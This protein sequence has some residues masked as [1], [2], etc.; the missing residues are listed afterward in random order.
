VFS[1]YGISSLPGLLRVGIIGQFSLPKGAQRPVVLLCGFFF[2][3]FHALSRPFQKKNTSPRTPFG[4]PFFCLPTHAHLPKPLHRVRKTFFCTV[5]FAMEA[6]G[7]QNSSATP[8]A[9]NDTAESNHVVSKKQAA[10]EQKARRDTHLLRLIDGTMWQN[11]DNYIVED[12]VLKQMI[13]FH[14]SL[15]SV[16]ML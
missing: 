11:L 1:A 7:M 15:F 10:A 2:S 8:S 14:A 4:H 13:G 12:N 16:D 6:G 5:S 3:P 9:V